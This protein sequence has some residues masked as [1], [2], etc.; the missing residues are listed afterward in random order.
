MSEMSMS[1]RRRN[2]TLGGLSSLLGD[3]LKESIVGM[4]AQP[5]PMSAECAPSGDP[6]YQFGE[7][8]YFPF[9]QYVDKTQVMARISLVAQGDVQVGDYFIQGTQG[10]ER[11]VP[12]RTFLDMGYLSSSSP[13][14]QA[15]QDVATLLRACEK[16]DLHQRFEVDCPN[17]YWCSV[18]NTWAHIKAYLLSR[19]YRSVSL[20]QAPP[21][22]V[23]PNPT[24]FEVLHRIYVVFNA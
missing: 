21:T 23:W 11:H 15:W 1:D 16:F 2:A 10:D 24:C 8:V 4:A 22:V 5:F 9:Q 20:R 7:K 12:R 17:K 3:T 14:A 6:D 18:A 13:K 19:G